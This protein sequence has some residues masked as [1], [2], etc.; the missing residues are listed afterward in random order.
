[1]RKNERKQKKNTNLSTLKAKHRLMKKKMRR[2][3]IKKKNKRSKNT[4]LKK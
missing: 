1:M 4:K 2:R 3:E